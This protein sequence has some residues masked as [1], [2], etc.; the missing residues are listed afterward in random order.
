MHVSLMVT[1]TSIC[2]THPHREPKQKGPR[3]PGLGQREPQEPEQREQPEQREPQPEQREQPGQREPQERPG[4][5]EPEPEQWR[6]EPVVVS[7]L[8]CWC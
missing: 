3:E 8:K 5:K 4:Q 7:N 6:E 2:C 1:V